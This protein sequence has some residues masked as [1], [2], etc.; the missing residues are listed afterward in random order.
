[1]NTPRRLHGL[2]WLLLGG[3][4]ALWCAR[5]PLFPVVL[6]PAY[7][8]FIAQQV[9]VADGPILFEPWEAAPLGRPHLYPPVFHLLL[10]ALLKIGWHPVTVMR[11]A[12]VILPPL[13]LVTMLLMARRLFSPSVAL[14]CAWISVLPWAFHLHGAMAMAA[15]LGLIELLW[16]VMA[17]E[18]RR[19]IAA[20]LLFV[21]LCYT[22]LGLPWIALVSL[23]C[24]ALM[25]PGLR[26][27]L[28]RASWALVLVLPWWWYLWS[29]RVLLHTVPRFE[30]TFVEFM[31]L[32]G[33]AGLVG[34]WRCWRQGG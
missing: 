17:L 11:C 29:H 26:S 6:D 4:S 13:L 2:A 19:V 20:G 9:A 27:D 12:S 24:A 21:L 14:S 15:W 16:P 28:W 7:H 34:A 10:A 32:I 8:L 25:R 30:N 1:M 23:G 22:H 5:W 18:R 33:M 3:F 31:P